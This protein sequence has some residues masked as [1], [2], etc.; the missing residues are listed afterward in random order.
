MDSWKSCRGLVKDSYLGRSRCPIVNGYFNI[1]ISNGSL[2]LSM[3]KLCG[4]KVKDVSGAY[5][6]VDVVSWC[7]GTQHWTL[8]DC[9]L[10][11]VNAVSMLS[12]WRI[13]DRV[14]S[15]S[16]LPASATILRHGIMVVM[17]W[18]ALYWKL[19]SGILRFVSILINYSEIPIIQENNLCKF[20]LII[21][22]SPRSHY[23]DQSLLHLV[24]PFLPPQFSIG[25]GFLS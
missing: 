9:P 1:M 13:Q 6:Q 8:H 10:L 14:L 15:S 12:C 4:R 5:R 18:S 23:W 17:I 19:S 21:L 22:M 7:G 11:A 16:N 20:P 2:V 24:P 3:H 25:T